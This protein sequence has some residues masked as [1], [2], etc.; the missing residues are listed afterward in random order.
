M[1]TV[2]SLSTLWQ[3]GIRH[4]LRDV[5]GCGHQALCVCETWGRGQERSGLALISPPPPDTTSRK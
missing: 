3:V 5:F 1:V 4:A 2:L